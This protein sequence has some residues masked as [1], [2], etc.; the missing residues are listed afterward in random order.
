MKVRW[1]FSLLFEGYRKLFTFEKMSD[2]TEYVW[3]QVLS[4]A[5]PFLLHTLCYLSSKAVWLS[6]WNLNK[7]WL[8]NTYKNNI[9]VESYN[10]LYNKHTESALLDDQGLNSQLLGKNP[11]Q[12]MQQQRFLSS[13]WRRY[14]PQHSYHELCSQHYLISLIESLS[15]VFED[16]LEYTEVNYTL[17]NK[18]MSQW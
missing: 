4:M 18:W 2:I 16:S 5:D 12:K 15:W 11:T 10:I 8:H 6:S 14:K 9:L 7:F 3:D 1:S 17:A 13:S